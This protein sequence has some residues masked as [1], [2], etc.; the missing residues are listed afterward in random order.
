MKVSGILAIAFTILA[1]SMLIVLPLTANKE[2]DHT[3]YT[4]ETQ[5]V[6]VT[7]VIANRVMESV[8]E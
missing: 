3:T 4:N 6:T 5:N 2:V 1:V 8:V 7:R